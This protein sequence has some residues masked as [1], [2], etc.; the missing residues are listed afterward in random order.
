MPPRAES[1]VDAVVI[2]SG[3]GGSVAAYRLA[4]AG[5]SV[6][7]LERGKAYP[8]GSFPRRPRE[9]A[10]NVW[11]PS[12]GYHGLF[13]V[14]TFRGIEALVA[15]GLGGGSLIYAN[16]LLR[17]DERWFVHEHP[18]GGGVEH[19]PIGRADLEPHYDRVE[20]MLGAQPFPLG[21]PGYPL[22]AK[23]QALRDAAAGLGLEWDRPPLAVTFA[24]P[25][26]PAAVGEPI[27]EGDYPNF[28]G[29]PRRTCRLCGECDVGCNDGSKNTLDHTYLSAARHRG[30]DIRTRCEVH[31]I[32]RSDGGGFVV[33]YVPYGSADEG[34]KTNTAKLPL[35]RIS[36]DRLVVAAGTLGTTGLLLRNRSALPGLGAALGTRFCGNGDLLGI[37]LD[38]HHK[39]GRRPPLRTIDSSHG[40]VITSYVRVP[41]S[42]DGGG[43]PGHY[44]EDAGYPVAID[45]MAEAITAPSRY[46]RLLRV[47]VARLVSQIRR[48]PR[49]SLSVELASLIGD[50][51]LSSSSLPLLGMGRDVPDGVMRLKRGQLDIDWTTATS[52]AY[53]DRLRGT[54]A[55]LAGELGGDLVDNPLSFLKKVVTVHP[56]G[57]APMGRHV[58]EG[59]VDQWGESFAYPGLYVLDGSAMPG[60]VGANPSLTIAAFA[61]RAVEHLLESTPTGSKGRPT[62]PVDPLPPRPDDDATTDAG[63]PSVSF[64]EE[65]KGFITFDMTDHRAAYEAGRAAG[66]AF[67]F[68][69]TITAPDVD[70]F[71]REPAHHGSATGWVECDAL[72][73]RM[74]V[75]RGDFNLFVA[76]AGPGRTHM[77]YRLYVTDPT[78]H[79]LTM[80]GYKDVHDDA[81]FDVWTD[82]STLYIRLLHGHVPVADDAGAELVASGI[83]RILVPDFARQL[84]T[85]RAHG[86]AGPGDR[87][88]ALAAF[89]RSFLGD[90]WDVFGG[91][92]GEA[93]DRR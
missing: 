2:G 83:L 71:L 12:R 7:V 65:M 53:F 50:A 40:P 90:L 51:S 87:A 49:S 38:A 81:G 11:D 75:E 23:T 66:T 26:R 32:E 42:V 57:G 64:T 21:A 59:V 29:L 35:T 61:D 73:G 18:V 34:R 58:G 31:S 4:D 48:S 78:G 62:R 3:F 92:A 69:L 74:A 91:R 33:G 67:M 22:P 28:H 37:V 43:G 39:G 79:P 89:G 93:V 44:V 68:H 55:A 85:F 82:T 52:R 76:D 9:M 16:V 8:P 13:D 24:A 86:G 19:W 14:W 10:T 70:R 27:P 41:D 63:A 88:R 84:T 30:A 20:Q 6:V 54:M 25:G 80:S 47:V 46:R 1:H 5:R 17:K 45:W 72:G 56:L 60:P 15:S 36:C 77:Y